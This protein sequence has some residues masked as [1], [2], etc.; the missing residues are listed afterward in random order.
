MFRGRWEKGLGL[1]KGMKGFRE[2][3]WDGIFKRRE[4]DWG[5]GRKGSELGKHVMGFRLGW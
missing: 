1:G 5:R 4:L 2:G 3:L